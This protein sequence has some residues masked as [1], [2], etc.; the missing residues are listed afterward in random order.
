[1]AKTVLCESRPCL[2]EGD[3]SGERSGSP[4]TQGLPRAALPLLPLAALAAFYFRSLGHPS[5][6]LDEAWE[7]N[8]YLG[9]VPEPWYNRPVLYMAGVRFVTH[10]LGPGEFA[11]RLLPCLAGL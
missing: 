10:L 7:A 3:V 2:H 4:R 11:L 5:L 6:W 8:Y 1:H 9:I